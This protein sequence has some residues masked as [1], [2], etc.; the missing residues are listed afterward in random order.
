MRIS[1]LIPLALPLLLLTPAVPAH[2]AFPGGNGVLVFPLEAPAGD[3][4]QTDIYTIQPGGTGLR[5]LTATPDENE[6]G[7]A[8]N[9]AGTRIAFW[10]TPAPFGP[11]TI[12]TMKANGTDQRRLTTGVD[13]RDPAWSPSGTRIVFTLVGSDGFDLWTM[14]ASDGGDRRQLTSG[15]DV[16]FEPAWSPDGTRIAFTRG[17]MQGDP[18]DV[19][20]LTLATGALTR[21]TSSAEYDHQVAWSPDGRR[22]VFER[23][24]DTF[25][26]IYTVN[27][28]GTGLTR[29]TDGPFFDTGPA[30]SPDGR[31]IAFGSN[32]GGGFLDDLWLVDAD[33]TGLRRIRELLQSSESFPDWRPVPR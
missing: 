26:C 9:A 27:V 4:T 33:G 22:L 21:V 16:D 31:F 19:Y 3:H 1:R 7:P 14:R 25:F 17:S 8:W 23:D 10:G 20:V 28:D 24:A 11:G 12:W 29:I 15:P 13:A 18:G 32:R 5:R 2:A 30:F 6:F